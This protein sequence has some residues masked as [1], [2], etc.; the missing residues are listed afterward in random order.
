MKDFYVLQFNGY[1]VI[2]QAMDAQHAK[3]VSNSRF[4]RRELDVLGNRAK[5]AREATVRDRKWVAEMSTP[6]D[7]IA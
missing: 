1:S 7:M 2:V 3:D 4:T 6:L 5:Y